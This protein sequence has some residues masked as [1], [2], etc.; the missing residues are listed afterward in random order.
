[1]SIVETLGFLYSAGIASP[2]AEAMG[3]MNVLQELLK[4]GMRTPVPEPSITC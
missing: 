2:H 4:Q 3:R 1:M